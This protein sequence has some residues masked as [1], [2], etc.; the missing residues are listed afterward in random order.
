MSVSTA[1]PLRRELLIAFVLPTL[2]LG[3][4]HGPEGQ[5]QAIYAKHAGVALTALALAMLLT[6]IFD[7][8]TYPLIGTLSDRSQARRGTRRNWIVAGTILS[9]VG[10]WFLL[11]PP[12]RVNVVYFGVCM[13]ITYL[14]W[15]FIEIPLQAWSFGLSSDYAQRARVQAW[16][17]LALVIGQLLFYATP[18]LAMRLGYSDTT[19]LDFRSLGLAATICVVALPLATTALLLRVPSGAVSP[20]SARRRFGVKETLAAVRSNPPL[21]RL[22]MAFLPANVLGGLSN[23]VAYFY[24]DTYLGLSKNF[25]AIFMLAILTSMVG[26]PFW[27]ALS[28]RYE[29]HRVWACCLVAA[30]AV[31]AAFALVTPG[32]AA[33]VMCFVLYPALVFCLSGMV[34]VYTMSA[35]IVDYGRLHTGEDHGGLY[36]SMFSFLQKSLLGVSAAAG[37]ALIGAFGFDATAATQSANGVLGI[38]LAFAICPAAGVLGAAAIIWNYPLNRKRIAGIQ[39]AL[40]EQSNEKHSAAR[41]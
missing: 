5:I 34:M 26:I 37:V 23:G 20:Q 38:K 16:R 22:L 7:G 14:G 32:P 15:K 10:V 1:I 13:A 4:M 41:M 39:A 25:S 21:V 29:R 11:R 6:K 18:F 30:S 31:Q 35:D 40:A 33:L 36:G 12:P 19:Q 27:T 2:V 8:L 17:T 28:A 3:A 24:I 9:M